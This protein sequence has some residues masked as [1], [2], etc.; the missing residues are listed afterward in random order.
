MKATQNNFPEKKVFDYLFRL[1]KES[2]YSLLEEKLIIEIKKF[3]S[4]PRLYNLMGA[5]LAKQNRYQQALENFNF[6]LEY[7]D[8][9]PAILNNIGIT[10]IK[11]EN[12]EKAVD[13]FREAIFLDPD[14]A[15]AHFNLGNALRK[16]GQLSSSITSYDNSI[17]LNPRYAKAYL[18]KSLSLKN[19]GK[20]DE[21]IEIC[22]KAIDKN[23]KI[24][25]AHRHLSSMLNYESKTQPH[26]VEMVSIF[27]SDSINTE[28]RIQL[29]FALGKA[30]EDIKDFKEA[31]YY[32]EIGNSLY[33]K[34]INY[35][36][37]SRKKLFHKLKN[38]FTRD[39]FDKLKKDSLLGE[40][41]IF[42]V[43]MPR[44]G[45]SLVE[46]ILSSHSQ[47]FGAGELR[48]FKEAVDESFYPIEDKKFP[49]N[50]QIHDSSKF[51]LL[52]KSYINSVS[53]LN[54]KGVN[55]IV[56]KMPYNFIYIGM[57]SCSLPGAK[58]ILCDRD[59]MDNCFSIYKQKFGIGNDYAYS[60]K[61]I[62]E[63]FN[64]YKDLMAYWKL[65]IPKKIFKLSYEKL[66]SNQE[67]ISRDM[68]KHCSLDWEKSCLS[69][70]STERDVLTASAVQV[71]QPL[72]NTSVN[73]W[74]NYKED[75]KVLS[76]ELN[77][78]KEL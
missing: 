24:G 36:T 7:S 55:F 40:N 45:T 3:P 33:R 29:A 56:D 27:N 11:L 5:C 21:S 22:N 70:H 38:N 46:Q 43:G 73:L 32:L 14:Y 25:I 1:E 47:V 78:R 49:E 41:I 19:L 39:F 66:I 4:S 31:F 48:S 17:K 20:F 26:L 68:V 63:Y 60:L 37:S 23:P 53:K 74:K 8:K 57:I 58:I 30:F 34:T 72:Y 15:L 76:T 50:L 59:P 28:D 61:E 13:I 51:E 16:K 6:A 35:S 12:F 64:L 18:Y 67:E 62:G 71:R 2:K 77:K 65:V 44:S 75:I 54:T 42:V 9:K 52:G 10:Q 69:F